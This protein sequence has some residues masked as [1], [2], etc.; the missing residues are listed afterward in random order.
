MFEVWKK[1]VGSCSTLECEIW[2]KCN[3]LCLNC[4]KTSQVG[5]CITKWKSTQNN[6]KDSSQHAMMSF[7]YT[8]VFFTET[9]ET[10][11][12]TPYKL[13]EWMVNQCCPN[14]W[15]LCTQPS[16]C[17][18]D[19]ALCRWVGTF[20]SFQRKWLLIDIIY[21]IHKYSLGNRTKYCFNWCMRVHTSFFSVLSIRFKILSHPIK[22]FIFLTQVQI[23]YYMPLS[24]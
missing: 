12:L 15:D 22:L 18:C 20:G 11:P 5:V 1:W 3:Y 2:L 24:I 9:L 17:E 8:F 21:R 4:G 19:S 13:M 6:Q 16:A 7:S 10:S 23:S 14:L